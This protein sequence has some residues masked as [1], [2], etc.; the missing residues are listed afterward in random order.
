MSKMFSDCKNLENIDLRSFDTK[1]VN[2][3]SEMF[4]G[5]SSLKYLNVYNFDTKNV[6]NMCEMFQ[7]LQKFNKFKC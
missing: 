7:E 5:C 2:N 1:N 6:T 4:H 3:M